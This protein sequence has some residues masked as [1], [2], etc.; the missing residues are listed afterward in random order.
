[1]DYMWPF[2]RVM[3]KKIWCI[4]DIYY[5]LSLSLQLSMPNKQFYELPLFGFPEFFFKN[6]SK[7]QFIS[8]FE[9]Y[10]KNSNIELVQSGG[11]KNR[12]WSNVGLEH[13]I[14]SI[15]RFWLWWIF[16]GNLRGLQSLWVYF[17]SGG[18]IFHDMFCLRFLY[19]C[20]CIFRLWGGLFSWFW[21]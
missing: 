13:K 21:L 1:M 20:G 14:V 4:L 12:V 2:G 15:F 8:Y 11:G 18:A 7:H 19:S 3:Q 5:T 17:G 16:Y 6:L 10:T 9:S